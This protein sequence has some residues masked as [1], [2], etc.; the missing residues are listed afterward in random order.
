MIHNNYTLHPI[1]M[2]KKAGLLSVFIFTFFSS[3]SQT[4]VG[5][6][7]Q[8]NVQTW[9]VPCGVTTVT[10]TAVGGGGGSANGLPGGDGASITGTY[11]VT[12]G[13]TLNI[14]TGGSGVSGTGVGAGGGGGG[15]T[16]VWD[17]TSN[18]LLVIAG[19]G[20]GGGF[21]GS[22]GGNGQSSSGNLPTPTRDAA[23]QCAAGGTGGLGGGALP[24]GNRYNGSGGAGWNSNGTAASSISGGSVSG[25]EDPANGAAGGSG[26]SV[27]EVGGYGGGGGS[28]GGGGG[29]GGFNGGG[30][31]GGNPGAYYGGGG[32]G[33]FSSVAPS[34]TSATNTGNGSVSISYSYTLLSTTASTIANVSCFGGSNGNANATPAGGTPPYTF[35]WA[36]SANSVVSASNPSGTVLLA[37]SYTVTVEDQAG[38]TVTASVSITQP[39]AAL[40][41]SSGG[42]VSF[43]K[44]NG[45]ALSGTAAGGTPP[46]TYEWSPGSE[47]GPNP[48]VNPPSTTTFTVTVT[49]ANNCTAFATQAVTVNT[50][51]NITCI[52]NQTGYAS[53]TICGSPLTYSGPTVLGLPAPTLTYTLSGTTTG[54]GSGT[55][56]G[57][58]FSLGATT[59]SITATNVCGTQECSFSVTIIDTVKPTIT[60]P[61]TVNTT[62]NTGCTAT[63][64][65]LGT[66]TT[67]DNCSVASVTNNAPSAFPLGNTKVTWTVTDGSGNTATANQTVTVTDNVNPTIVPPG[68]ITAYTNTGCTA[69]SVSLGTPTT[70]D[71]CSVA[72]VTNNAPSAFPLGNTTVTWKVTDGSGNTATATQTVT[73]RDTVVPVITAP[74]NKNTYTNTGCT[75]T[76]VNLG[77]PT[78]SDNCSV[79]SVTNNAPSAFPLGNTT[80]TWTVTDGSGNTATATQT[81]TVTDNV[82]PAILPPGTITAY[83]N[84]GCTATGVTLGTATTSDNCSVASVTNN[85]PSAFPLGNTTVTWTVTDGSGNTATATQIVSVKDTV[86]PTISAPGTI[87]A[88]N[89]SSVTLGTPLTNDNC[90]VASVKNNAPGSF[91]IGTTIITWTVTDGSGNTAS[92]NQQV[93]VNAVPGTPTAQSNSPVNQGDTLFFQAGTINGATYSWSGPNSFSSTLQNPYIPAVSA[94][95][96]GTYSVTATVDGCSGLAG[97]TSVSITKLLVTTSSSNVSCN[98]A[99]DG[100]AAVVSASGGTS[101]YTFAWSTLPVQTTEAIFNLTDGSYTVTITDATRSSVTESVTITQPS[102]ISIFTNTSAVSCFGGDNGSANAIAGGG[103]S[104]YSYSWNTSPVQ[105]KSTAENMSAGNYTVT[106]KDANGCPGTT[107][108]TITQPLNLG[109]TLTAMNSV[110]GSANGSVSAVVSGG[111]SSY[112]YVWSTGTTSFTS[113]L[114]SAI[115]LLPSGSYSVTVTDLNG[116]SAYSSAVVGTTP[117]NFNLAFTANPQ[118]GAS[119]LPV[120]FSNN[121]PNLSN[122]S[123]TWYWGDGNSDNDNNATVFYTYNFAGTYNVALIATDIANGCSDTLSKNPFINVTGTGCGNTVNISPSGPISLCQGD[124]V[125]LHAKTSAT[126]SFTYQWNI[127]GVGISGESDS[128]I[129]VTQSGFYNVTMVKNN[130]PVSSSAVQV[131]FATS[132]NRPVISSSGTIVPCQGGAVTLTSSS[133][134]GG[135]YSW[136][137]GATTESIVVTTSGIYQVT[138]TNGAGCSSA[139]AIDTMNASL[140]QIDLCMVTVDDSSKY[141]VLIWQPPATL[142]IDSFIIYREITTGNYQQIG[143]QPYSALSQFVDTVR[144][145]YFP[146]TGDPNVGAYRYKIQVRDT[147]GNYSNLS[148]FHNTVFM[149]QNAGTFTWNQYGIE[150]QPVPIPALSSYVLYRDDDYSGFNP[151]G[152]VAGSQTTLSDPSYLSYPN[153]RWY[154]GTTWSISCTPS[155]GKIKAAYSTTKSNIKGAASAI[156]TGIAAQ[157]FA[158]AVKMYPNPA[159]KQVNLEFPSGYKSY[160]ISIFDMIGNVILMKNIYCSPGGPIKNTAQIDINDFPPGVYSLSITTEFLKVV[161]KLVVQ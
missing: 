1:T 67:A 25:G 111:T 155:T 129:A 41:V 142:S 138:V 87:T 24:S 4:N 30:G 16:Y 29:G 55:G 48:S 77:T 143:A 9:T 99:S 98:G 49:D 21:M 66:A 2:H 42:P 115:T 15:G 145:K 128:L 3:F 12:S 125:L 89:G 161:K 44:N 94:A 27:A 133:I 118:N 113:S 140:T 122:Y 63:G 92:A 114:T 28:S 70:S 110:C 127:G 84:T 116:C 18:S 124:T 68:T 90:S 6:G 79:A 45:T 109:V 156:E 88:C 153:A 102:P 144:T 132:P 107:A 60:A 78:T 61:P 100:A 58:P 76:G 157:V 57:S 59:V 73:V 86:A 71:N 101:P 74:A 158:S 64:I 126:A 96:A 50:P 11:P 146:N 62:T 123:F 36:N 10:I 80:V 5:F 135:T 112:T 33:S 134:A 40:T 82:D 131:S 22:A 130:C 35:S 148:P 14:I 23:N 152:S 108:V 13:H 154:V 32:G 56:S 95:A 159:N 65:T 103:T 26:G 149:N 81:V 150:G 97:T 34:T 7:F 69:T 120:T 19:G 46:V 37:G 91:P 147:C 20:G 83:T 72:S 106:V 105:T 139:S 75:A 31:G 17:A 85:A 38:C 121:T 51:P 93:T 117:A 8:A 151:I 104:P 52:G 43:C 137:T 136:S 119:P 54:N 141:N 160:Q 47:N 53:E 39:A